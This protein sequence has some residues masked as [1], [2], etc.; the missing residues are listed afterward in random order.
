MR[1]AVVSRTALVRALA[2][3]CALLVLAAPAATAHTMLDAADPSPGGTVM[4][5]ERIRLGFA[6]AVDPGSTSRVVLLAP[7]GSR[8]DDGCVVLDGERGLAVGVLAPLPV[9]GEYTVRWCAVA[10]DGHV[11]RGAYVFGYAGS[12][13]PAAPPAGPAA[14]PPGCLTAAEPAPPRATS[15]GGPAAGWIVVGAVALA[16]LGAVVARRV[17]RRP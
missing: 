8:R 9:V 17:S 13:D 11:Q 12:V 10:A 7:D 4:S 14:D 15:G 3:A 16:L 2:L 1:A 5:L 6:G